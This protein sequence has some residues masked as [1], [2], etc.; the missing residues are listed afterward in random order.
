MHK[1]ACILLVLVALPLAQANAQEFQD[2]FNG[3]D[4]TGWAG[5][6]GFWSVQ[7]GAIVGE[8]TK[9]N[10]AKPNTFL[11]WQGGE[12]ADF[13]FKALVRFKGNNSGVQYRSELIDAK[14]FALK[15]YQG[16][17]H[18]KPEYFGMMYG[19]KTGR[20][21]I[22]QRF[23]RVEVGADGKSNVLAE[24]GDKNQELVDSQWNEIRIIAVGNRM[25]HQNQRCDDHGTDRQPSRCILNRGS[26]SAASCRSAD[27]GGIQEH[28]VSSARW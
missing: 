2:L 1:S 9:E 4:L 5:K 28:S 15:G 24:I 21:I 14:N 18:P 19:E 12:V 25:V 17:L 22:A 26:R 16:D 23:Q 11:V 6:E 27:E 7:A 13:E 3:K 20:G 10:P 8:T